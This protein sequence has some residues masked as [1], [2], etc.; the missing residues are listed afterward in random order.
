MYALGLSYDGGH[1]HLVGR[2][3]NFFNNRILAT[4]IEHSKILTVKEKK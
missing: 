4:N 2:H 3:T 1:H